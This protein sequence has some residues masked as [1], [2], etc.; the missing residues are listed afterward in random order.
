MW[1][2]PKSK[3]QSFQCNNSPNFIVL[4]LKKTVWLVSWIDIYAR[5]HRFKI[6][7]L[8]WSPILN[9]PIH[10]EHLAW[11]FL[12]EWAEGLGLRSVAGCHCAS[13]FSY[14]LVRVATR[15]SGIFNVGWYWLIHLFVFGLHR[16]L[17]LHRFKEEDELD[18]A[19]KVCGGICMHIYI[20]LYCYCIPDSW[21][22]G[23]IER[24]PS[25]SGKLPGTVSF[26]HLHAVTVW[27]TEGSG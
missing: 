2:E 27:Q 18:R 22:N 1:K 19:E 23:S 5:N 7:P 13:T 8:S 21:I 14:N 20:S 15:I 26:V 3:A 4:T 12:V 10:R 6:M 11:V 24:R 25:F 17:T 9:S 16:K